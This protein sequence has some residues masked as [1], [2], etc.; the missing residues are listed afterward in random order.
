[1]ST[2]H[3]GRPREPNDVYTTPA[4]C[5]D[6]L[7][8]HLPARLH[9]WEPACGPARSIVYALT[10]KGYTVSSSD[11]SIGVDFLKTEAAP[12]GVTAIVTN[13]PYTRPMPQRFIEHSLMLMKPVG[14][15]VAMLLRSAYGHA[16]TRQH[17]FRECPVFA[18]KI[19]LTARVRWYPI[20]PG[21]DDDP[22]T[23]HCWHVW[24]W[25]HRGPAELHFE[26]AQAG[27]ET[28]EFCHTFCHTRFLPRHTTPP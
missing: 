27:A 28:G 13:P 22:S 17:L 18:C 7:I 19:E 10:A 11:I 24:D 26:P 6:A 14:G 21:S 1:M 25:R 16:K 3:S 12:H 4:W 15:M 9:V 20:G 5:V 23:D 2:R 8:P